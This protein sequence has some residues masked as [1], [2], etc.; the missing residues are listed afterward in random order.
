MPIP[1]KHAI[2]EDADGAELPV[3]MEAT[4]A[5][6][7]NKDRDV[8]VVLTLSTVLA[9]IA[10]LGAFAFYSGALSGLGPQTQTPRAVAGQI[11]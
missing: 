5:R 6:S 1:V 7:G 4:D 9:V 11:Q 10:L 8:V 3:H 2:A